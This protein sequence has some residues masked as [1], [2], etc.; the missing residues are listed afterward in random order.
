MNNQFVHGKLNN[1]GWLCG[2]LDMGWVIILIICRICINLFV[3][4]TTL[5]PLSAQTP[6]L[7]NS[8]KAMS[9]WGE[10]KRE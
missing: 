1:L 5:C 9:I 4:S 2:W 10:G 7:F 8:L 3:R 6:A